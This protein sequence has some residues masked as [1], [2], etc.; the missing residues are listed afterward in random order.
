MRYIEGL[1]A[2][3]LRLYFGWVFLS[4]GIEKW[5]TGFG[6]TAVSGYLKGALGKTSASLLTTKGPAAAAHPDVTATWAWVINHILLPNAGLF[7]FLVKLGEVAIG[8]ALI[9][10]L[11][12]HLA[13]GLG[14]FMSFV[15]LFSGTASITGPTILAF[16]IIFW[17]GA[18]SYLFGLDRFFMGNL[19]LHHPNLK[20]HVVHT[21]FP[22]YSYKPVPKKRD[23]KIK[24]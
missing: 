9:I 11:F 23:E 15:Y 20:T 19:V 1:V 2:L 16:L 8:I 22:A 18:E 6:A 12:T 10:G 17:L 14:M 21:F 4:S 24:E 7:A 3:I 5:R 13:A